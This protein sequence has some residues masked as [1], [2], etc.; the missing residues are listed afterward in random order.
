MFAHLKLWD[1]FQI[2]GATH[3]GARTTTNQRG[4]ITCHTIQKSITAGPFD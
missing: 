1:A 4:E 2:I 3:R